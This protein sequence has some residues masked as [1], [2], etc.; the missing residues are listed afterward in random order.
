MS[1][2]TTPIRILSDFTENYKTYVVSQGNKIIQQ[3]SLSGSS[4]LSTDFDPEAS[5]LMVKNEGTVD[6]GLQFFDDD[7][8]V[9]SDRG[10]CPAG[11]AV[12]LK[13]PEGA[14]TVYSVFSGEGEVEYITT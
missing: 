2:P 10:R 3:L 8:N 4:P 14:V 11:E 12:A 5:Y 1:T 7:F 13:I 6:I 9:I